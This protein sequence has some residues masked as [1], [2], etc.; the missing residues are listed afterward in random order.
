MAWKI[1]QRSGV[2][3]DQGRPQEIPRLNATR[4]S[5]GGSTCHVIGQRRERPYSAKLHRNSG[6]CLVF[7]RP[8]V[9]TSH[10]CTHVCKLVLGI[11]SQRQVFFGYQYEFGFPIYNSRT[12][13]HGQGSQE[14]FSPSSSLSNIGAYI[15]RD[16]IPLL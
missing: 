14:E 1:Q 11:S 16:P 8:F 6:S 12:A 3:N 15:I 5:E 9:I 10:F 2:D 13:K 4:S 7:M